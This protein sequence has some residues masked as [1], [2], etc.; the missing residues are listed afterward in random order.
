M[1]EESHP[2]DRKRR[3]NNKHTQEHL[4]QLSDKD[5]EENSSISLLS[6]RENIVHE[7]GQSRKGEF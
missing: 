7:D 4:S 6:D 1:K 5:Y 3:M 2:Q